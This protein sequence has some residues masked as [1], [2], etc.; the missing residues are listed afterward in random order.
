MKMALK[1]KQD[2]S[3]DRL[4]V[5]LVTKGYNLKFGIDH[6]EAFSP[7]AKLNSIRILISLA[8]RVDRKLHQMDMKNT[9]LHGDLQE[10]VYIQQPPNVVV[11][12]ESIKVCKLNKPIYELKQSPRAWFKKFNEILTGGFTRTTSNFLIFVKEKGQ[13]KDALF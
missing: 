13:L 5:M 3:I 8:T 6:E 4:K 1:F 12:G 10:E 11:E 7:M 2:D 9:F